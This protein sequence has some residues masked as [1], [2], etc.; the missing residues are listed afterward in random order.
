M[1]SRRWLEQGTDSVINTTTLYEVKLQLTC[2]V[3]LSREAVSS[4]AACATTRGLRVALLTITVA[5]SL[6]TLRC[7]ARVYARFALAHPIFRL[8]SVQI[9]YLCPDDRDF[10]M[11][12]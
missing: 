9:V 11:S 8:L 10:C 12:C 3:A 7:F 6:P 2:R 1:S 4:G 5:D